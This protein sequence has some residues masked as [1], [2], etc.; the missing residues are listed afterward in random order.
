MEDQIEH[1]FSYKNLKCVVTYRRDKKFNGFCPKKLLVNVKGSEPKFFAFDEL[2][3][4]DTEEICEDFLIYQTERFI[5]NNFEMKEEFIK[6]YFLKTNSGL[7]KEEQQKVYDF[8]VKT[9]QEFKNQLEKIESS[10][11]KAEFFDAMTKV[12]TEMIE[13]RRLLGEKI[14]KGFSDKNES[15]EYL[16]YMRSE[17]E[18]LFQ[19]HMF[20]IELFFRKIFNE[21]IWDEYRKTE[22]YKKPLKEQKSNPNIEYKEIDW[23]NSKNVIIG[24][25]IVI[26]VML[27]IGLRSQTR[28]SPYDKAMRD[29]IQKNHPSFDTIDCTGANSQSAEC[30]YLL[31]LPYD[32]GGDPFPY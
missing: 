30:R 10:T 19:Q 8:F 25:A 2:R 3:I 15:I 16:K 4:L 32:P 28:I 26:I 21:S 20:E 9:K 1:K 27:I 24:F 31:N 7:S 29:S 22:E 18:K 6:A 5:D 14:E 17:R 12:R 23:G 11:K 13:Q